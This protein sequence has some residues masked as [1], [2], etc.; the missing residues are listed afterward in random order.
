MLLHGFEDC[1]IELKWWRP[2]VF[3]ILR[4]E[5]VESLFLLGVFKAKVTIFAQAK[6]DVDL[7]IA[8]RN[9]G[10]GIGVVP[11]T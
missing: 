5:R 8:Q 3:G 4:R 11:D 1:G 7:V 10:G 9:K 2:A 6:D